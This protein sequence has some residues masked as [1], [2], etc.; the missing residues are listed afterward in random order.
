MA[1]ALSLRN[2]TCIAFILT[3]FFE[4]WY[5]EQAIAQPILSVTQQT[6]L[7]SIR[8]MLSQER[9]YGS[10]CCKLTRVDK[11]DVIIVEATPRVLSY[12]ILLKCSPR[13]SLCI[14]EFSA[15]W[16]GKMRFTI[17]DLIQANQKNSFASVSLDN[18]GDPIVGMSAAFIAGERSQHLE[19]IIDV[20][21]GQ[22]ISTACM[23]QVIPSEIFCKDR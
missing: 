7:A 8:K 3:V 2:K 11:D 16:T 19:G 14:L 22:M 23:L 6:L 18:V 13:P 15:G 17:Q 1:P 4:L 5:A 21:H 12:T 20:W 10:K 9:L